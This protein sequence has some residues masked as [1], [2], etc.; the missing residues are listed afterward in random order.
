MLSKLS[1]R[2]K[3]LLATLL[4][5]VVIYTGLFFYIRGR[6]IRRSTAD[7]EE[8]QQAMVSLYAT[9][10]DDN[11]EQMVELATASAHALETFPLASEQQLYSFLRRNVEMNHLAYGMAIAFTP[12]SFSPRKRLFAPYVYKNNGTLVQ[13]DTGRI[14]DYTQPRWDWYSEAIRTGQSRWSDP[15][16]DEGAGDVWRVTYA[17]PFRRQGKVRGVATVDVALETLQRQ[18]HI[19]GLKEEQFFVLDR[20]GRIIFHGDP[21]FIGQSI[22]YI[23]KE[24]NRSDLEA[25]GRAMVSGQSGHL[26]MRDWTSNE[27][28][29]VFYTPISQ[30][31]WSLAIRLNEAILLAFIHEETRAGLLILVVSFCLISLVTWGVTGYMVR[32]IQQLDAAAHK[33]AVGDLAIEGDVDTHSQDE[34]GNLGRTFLDM[35][36]QLQESF[37]ELHRFNQRLEEEVMHRTAALEAA[38]QQLLEKERVLHDHNVALVQLSQSPHVQQGHFRM[39]LQEIIQVTATTLRVQRASAWELQGNRLKCVVQYDPAANHHTQPTYLTQPPYPEYL[40]LLRSGEPL[41]V[42]DL[43]TDPRTHELREYAK[44]QRVYSR[45]DAPIIFNGQLLGAICVESIGEHRVWLVEERS[46]VSNVADIVTIALAAHQRH[47]AERELLKAK[48]AAEAANKAKSIFLANMSHELRTPL[49]AILGFSQ[50]LLSDRTLTP[51][52]R[53]TLEKINRSGEHLLGLINDVLDMAKIEAGRIT[54]QETTFDLRRMLQTLEEMLKV[55]AEAKGLRLVFDLPANLPVAVTTDEM[56]LR[57]VLVN[58]LGNGIKFTKEGGVSLKV[59]YKAQEPPRLAFEVSDTGIGMTSAELK[60]LFQPFVQTDS[61]KKVSEGT[62]LGLAI[63]RQFVQLMGGDIQVRSTKGQGSHFYFEINIGLGD[64]QALEEE[65][66]QTVVGLRSPTSEVRILVV[67][68]IPENRQLLT[69]LLEPVGF[70]CQEA[71]NGQE[72]VEIWREWQ[73]HAIL[74]DIRMPVMDGKTATRQIKK[75]VGD[76]LR[77]GEAVCPPK[78]L[79]VTA[80]SFEQDKQELLNLGCDDYIAKPFRPQTIFERLAAQLNLEYVYEDALPPA[81]APR[82]QVL[83]PAALMVM[84]RP[85]IAELQEAAKKLDGKRIRELIAE[86]PPEEAALIAGLQQLVKTFRFDKIIE[87]TLV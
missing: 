23:A 69:Q 53:Q 36:G 83:D 20:K 11:L 32:P 56:K 51:Q 75:E 54:L 62:G 59:S 28:Q 81:S 52:Q 82:P 29:W 35:A 30:A 79:A 46:F 22:F 17:V 73:P 10:F 15:Y 4:P 14:Y 21:Q 63:S 39:A 72:A 18:M 42:N 65:T 85:W 8:W 40:K 6:V 13:K 78:I 37:A 80:S 12:Y 44:L 7:Y 61:S 60:M 87:L 66:A 24:E 64:P 5:I 9:Q 67:D 26:R 86:I 45:I 77:R 50:I 68:D 25:L 49:N 27:R 71:S 41:V 55:R 84:P 1:F 31:G 43:L 16:F 76:R 57:Q 2:H 33:I 34:V 3:L 70:C 74:M 48:E 19:Q 47:Q 58:L 38:N